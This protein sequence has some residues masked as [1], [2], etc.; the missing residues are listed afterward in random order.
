MVVLRPNSQGHA[1]LGLAIS[2]KVLAR[3]VARNQV[4]RI[5]RDS[6]RRHAAELP[7]YDIVVSLS[8]RKAWP[9]PQALRGELDRALN[10]TWQHL[11][12]L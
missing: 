3:A 6:F 8:R 9:G 2:K 11:T 12:R 5:V 1:R 4:K 7:A 10:S